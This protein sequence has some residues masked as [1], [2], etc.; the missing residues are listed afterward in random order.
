MIVI[1]IGGG[2]TINQQAIIEDLKNL[3]EPFIIIHGGNYMLDTIL[4]KFDIKKKYYTSPKGQIS[5]ATDQTIIDSMYMAY[6][7]YMNKSIV[8]AC[9]KNGINAVGLTGIDGRLLEGKRH[10]AFIAME[11]D[12]KKV[13]RDDLTGTVETVNTKLLTVL[14][15]NG[16]T[17]VITPPTITTD[18]EVINTD[19]D[20]IS[21]KIATE[22]KADTLLFLIETA[23]M[24]TNFPD[25]TTLIKNIKRD[26]I[27]TYMPNA[28]GRMK[29]KLQMSK[30][31]LEKG[32]KQIVIADGRGE[33]PVTK[34][35][36]EKKGTTLS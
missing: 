10:P 26:E 13:I 11:D 15:S 29:K 28:V 8:A 32:I 19:G 31:A 23:G 22:M 18:N 16:F 25:E 21:A 6:A 34:A 36:R 24:L 35:I 4:E 5:R 3:N 7:G 30:W 2:K 1:K 12:K 27:E 20:K 33:T 9:Q 17:P 14:I